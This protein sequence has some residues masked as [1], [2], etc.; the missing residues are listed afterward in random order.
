MTHDPLCP[1]AK[2]KNKN[3]TY[4]FGSCSCDLIARVREDM[5]RWPKVAEVYM[6]GR[7]AGYKRGYEDATS[8]HRSLFELPKTKKIIIDSREVEY[9]RV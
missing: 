3:V 8:L 4:E 9:R 6:K 1:T 2:I 5:L 7:D